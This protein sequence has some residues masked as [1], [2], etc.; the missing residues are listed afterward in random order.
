MIK[1]L[2]YKSILCSLLIVISSYSHYLFAC[3]GPDIIFTSI[4]ITG[5]NYSSPQFLINYDYQIKNIG[6]DTIFIK[7][8]SIQNYVS[9]DN[10][11]SS[12]AAAGGS[13]IDNTSSN[14]L[15][16]G[17]TY[18]GTFTAYSPN[19]FSTYPYLIPLLI[20]Y[21]S[22][23]SECD[24]SNNTIVACLHPDPAITNLTIT[25]V[26]SGSVQYDYD[27]KNVGGDTLFY[28]NLTIQNYVST[29]N[30]YDGADPSAGSTQISSSPTFLTPNQTYSGSFT[31]T[32]SVST[33]TYNYLITELVYSSTECDATNNENITSIPLLSAT[34]NSINPTNNVI[35]KWN[36][37]AK[38]FSVNKWE[39]NSAGSLQ[40]KIYNPNGTL[41][42]SSNTEI[43][44]TTTLPILSSGLY[45]LIISDDQ[46]MHSEK[47]IY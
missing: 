14:Y 13:V 36:S 6:T 37:D 3:T 10:V 42:F 2:S 30:V 28:S 22:P 39:N 32:P 43:F 29:D 35:V 25:S 17:Q 31:A 1:Q 33:D 4:T 26:S 7:Y 9:T 19:T 34:L 27:I 12:K 8:L 5:V 16:S 11:G 47:I 20:Y 21:G 40:Y 44:E 41:I 24:A 45:I 23:V 15:L 46:K 38:S 18:S